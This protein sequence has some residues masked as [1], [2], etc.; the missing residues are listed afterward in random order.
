MST[1]MMEAKEMSEALS[2]A[3]YLH[4]WYFEMI[5]IDVLLLLYST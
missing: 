2:I 1:V 5:L 4:G 3:Q